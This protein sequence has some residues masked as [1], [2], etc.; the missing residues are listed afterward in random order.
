[1]AATWALIAV[2]S[3]AE[4]ERRLQQGLDA[5]G[6]VIKGNRPGRELLILVNKRKLQGGA[7]GD[8]PRI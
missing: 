6:A 7:G 4:I 2:R 5:Q 3:C 8:L 1:V